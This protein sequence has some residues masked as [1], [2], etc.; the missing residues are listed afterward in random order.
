MISTYQQRITLLEFALLIHESRHVYNLAALLLMTP[1]DICQKLK[2]T[3]TLVHDIH[4]LFRRSNA[5]D[6][7]LVFPTRKTLIRFV[8]EFGERHTMRSSPFF[9][10]VVVQFCLHR[11]WGDFEDFGFQSRVGELLAQAQGEAVERSF[12]SRICQ[13]GTMARLDTVLRFLTRFQRTGRQNM[14]THK[15]ILVAV[16]F[17]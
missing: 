13:A 3:S 14:V 16:D 15:T 5:T 6:D 8:T 12:R 17:D 4:E 9:A 7:D 11:R 1:H 10:Q 2:C